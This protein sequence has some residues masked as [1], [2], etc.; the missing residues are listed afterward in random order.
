MPERHPYGYNEPALGSYLTIAAAKISEYALLGKNNVL[1][2]SNDPTL[3]YVLVYN[4]TGSTLSKG[5]PVS[6]QRTSLSH[7]LY[8]AGSPAAEIPL[9][10]LGVPC[11]DIPTGSIGWVQIGGQA[12]VIMDETGA[13]AGDVVGVKAG[14]GTFIK[15][16][17]T[18]TA[19]GEYV[20]TKGAG[21]YSTV[22]L[23]G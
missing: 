16:T 1:I 12:S 10:F 14:G 21:T 11:V 17:D 9:R 18:W 6:V 8:V 15:V 22:F 3:K 23:F 13:S 7:A 2:G 4:N 5:V 20:A 19:L